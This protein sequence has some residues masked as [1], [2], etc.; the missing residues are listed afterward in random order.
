[1]VTMITLHSFAK[2]FFH[3]VR[4]IYGI[5]L[6]QVLFELFLKR[7]RSRRRSRRFFFFLTA[8]SEI[9]LWAAYSSV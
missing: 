8:C 9:F 4:G 3:V 2:L 1:M 5:I 6:R 7:T